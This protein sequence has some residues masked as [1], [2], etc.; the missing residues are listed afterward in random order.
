MTTILLG[1]SDYIKNVE[2][3]KRAYTRQYSIKPG[4]D[5]LTFFC[6][7]PLFFQSFSLRRFMLGFLVLL[8]SC[9]VMALVMLIAVSKEQENEGNHDH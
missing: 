5:W 7:S 3:A 8:V 6:Y 2:L 9:V 4:L 1:P